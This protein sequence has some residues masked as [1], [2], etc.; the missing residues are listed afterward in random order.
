MGNLISNIPLM[1]G[2]L[3]PVAS[4]RCH[5]RAQQVLHPVFHPW[6]MSLCWKPKYMLFRTIH[7]S[8][9]MMSRLRYHVVDV[10]HS[11]RVR[12]RI[13]RRDR[14]T[15]QQAAWSLSR[16]KRS[17]R[18]GL[19]HILQAVNHTRELHRCPRLRRGSFLRAK[20]HLKFEPRVSSTLHIPPKLTMQTS[21]CESPCLP[22][23]MYVRDL[24]NLSTIS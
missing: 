14:P 4:P 13:P 10:S 20:S 15:Q 21:C 11:F 22:K 9:R 17:H 16:S 3:V 2:V 7:P 5:R 6:M 19:A 12:T 8:L 18:P 24:V 1:V 23:R